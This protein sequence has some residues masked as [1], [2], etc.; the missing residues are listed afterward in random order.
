MLSL[1]RLQMPILLLLCKQME[2]RQRFTKVVNDMTIL[3]FKE[4]NS[5]SSL[6][7]DLD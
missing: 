7:M 1:G 2:S 5:N 3:F 4:N 6:R